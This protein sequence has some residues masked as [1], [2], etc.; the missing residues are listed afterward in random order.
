MLGRLE[1]GFKRERQFTADASHELRTPLTAIQTILSVTLQ[2]RRSPEDYE[3]ALADLTEE[4]DRLQTLTGGLLELARSEGMPNTLDQTVD[5]STLLQ[6]VSESL[7]PLAE[8]KGLTIDRNAS[9]GLTLRGD[10]DGLIR[11]FV[12]L[13][14]NAIQYTQQGEI[15]VTASREDKALQV[16]IADTGCGIRAEQL[17][18]IFDRFYRVDK[19]RSSRGAGLGLAIALEIAHSH[20][21][22]IEV[23]SEIGRGT[24]FTVWLPG[25]DA[26]NGFILKSGTLQVD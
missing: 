8:A 18:R 3:Q 13:L 25:P 1:R 17:P 19:S 6:D 22:T 9:E 16:A 15:T 24:T 14:H 20:G 5:L 21:G 2:K 10:S 26:R 7:R 23:T 11:L 12:N 4:T